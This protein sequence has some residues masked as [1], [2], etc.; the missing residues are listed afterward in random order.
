MRRSRGDDELEDTA[1]RVSSSLIARETTDALPVPVIPGMA[2]PPRPK[3]GWGA[4]TCVRCS[5]C[6]GS[7]ASCCGACFV[8]RG[9]V[10]RPP[11]N[12]ASDMGS[13]ARPAC[14][15]GALETAGVVVDNGEADGLEGAAESSPISFRSASSWLRCLSRVASGSS[16]GVDRS[17]LLSA[18]A[19]AL[20]ATGRRS[21]LIQLPCSTNPV[22]SKGSVK[23]DDA[24]RDQRCSSDSQGLCSSACGLCVTPRSPPRA[25][26][27]PL[28]RPRRPASAKP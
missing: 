5:N 25:S 17:S 22:D 23:H 14:A 4:E 8:S 12:A 6:V 27:S 7:C 24:H 18:A 13:A 26:V 19:A 3:T 2:T 15:G 10:A 9:P 11:M 28:P 16:P 21:M 1:D 20:W